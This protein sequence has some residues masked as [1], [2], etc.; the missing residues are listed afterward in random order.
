MHYD[1][2][3]L[4]TGNLF[5][6][7]ILLH[8]PLGITDNSG[9]KIYYSLEATPIKA[10]SLGIGSTTFPTFIIPPNAESYTHEAP[11]SSSCLDRVRTDSIPTIVHYTLIVAIA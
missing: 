3:H 8:I 2:P 10:G 9:M 5:L 4:H 7:N 6:L 11:C 1:N